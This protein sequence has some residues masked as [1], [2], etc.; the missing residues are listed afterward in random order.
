MKLDVIKPHLAARRRLVL[1]AGF[2][3]VLF[4]G[5]VLAENRPTCA[6]LAFEAETG[7]HLGQ[8]ALLSNRFATLLEQTGRY[9][10]LARLQVNRLLLASGFNRA[11]YGSPREMAV[12]VGKTL[13]VDRV[14]HGT[15]AHDGQHY[16]LTTFLLETTTG[17]AVAR[18]TSRQVGSID[19]LRGLVLSGNL[20]S[21][22]DL[23]PL[24]AL[25]KKPVGEVAAPR[26]A[27]PTP[28]MRVRKPEKKA[29]R[30]KA[31]PEPAAKEGP[32]PERRPAPSHRKRLVRPSEIG[33][34]DRNPWFD[35]KQWR[36]LKGQVREISPSISVLYTQVKKRE[37][38]ESGGPEPTRKFKHYQVSSDRLMLS[39]GCLVV[40][41]Y[42][43]WGTVGTAD[44]SLHA[45]EGETRQFDPASALGLGFETIMPRGAASPFAFSA[46]TSLL[47]FEADGDKIVKVREHPAYKSWDSLS[48]DW[49][50]FDVA[51]GAI[52]K[53]GR[54]RLSGGIQYVMVSAK[55]SGTFRGR[56]FSGELEQQESIG[57][58]AGLEY[59]IWRGL[60]AQFGVDFMAS[61]TFDFGLG[62]QF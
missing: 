58:F 49:S 8:A 47:I 62:Y 24:P 17:R 7:V 22:L 56:H 30:E 41:R 45:S 43:V 37:M 35:R 13:G 54:V 29:S 23:E 60:R 27:G 34:L 61:T 44:L 52:L 25:K 42:N 28:A 11:K 12:A 9:D 5:V 46:S 1:V 48:V 26:R 33:W 59:D 31:R 40:E 10:V 32:K 51:A 20:K 36:T 57:M 19:E 3:A 6:V 38:R 53:Q 55:E 21:L 14:F 2:S 15:V 18:A 50:E 4:R 16:T 39:A